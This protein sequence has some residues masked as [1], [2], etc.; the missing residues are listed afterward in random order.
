MGKLNRDIDIKM[1][2][3]LL[4]IVAILIQAGFL[5][6]QYRKD[7]SQ[8][9]KDSVQHGLWRSAKFAQSGWVAIDQQI[10]IFD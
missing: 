9:M 5:L 4:L 7:I 8:I 1:I 6:Y 3:H 10:P 2:I